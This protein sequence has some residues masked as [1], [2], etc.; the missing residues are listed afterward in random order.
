MNKKEDSQDQECLKDLLSSDPRV[1]KVRIETEKGGLLP[2]ACNWILEDNEFRRWREDGQSTPFWITG[3]PG[4][5]KTMMLC[6]IID[7]LTKDSEANVSFFFCQGTDKRLNSGTAV[8][9]GLLFFLLCKQQH[10]LISHIRHMYDDVGEKL[11]ED[12]NAWFSLSGI[13]KNTLKDPGLRQTY[14]I[15]DALD[16]CLPESRQ[17][18]AKLIVWMSS[19]YP[20]V[21]WVVSSRQLVEFKIHIG[22]AS[23]LS[24]ESR[25]ERVSEAVNAYINSKLTMLREQNL[26]HLKAKK[27]AKEVKERSEGTF[28]WV[29]IVFK[30]LENA[31]DY[32]VMD[33]LKEMPTG[34]NELYG[35]L[36]QDIKSLKWR[37]PEYCQSILRAVTTAF[38]PLTVKEVQEL[39]DLPQD[40]PADTIA[41]M[42]RSLLTLRNDT[43]FLVH[44]SAKDYLT[45]EWNT[46]FR[47]SIRATHES[48]FSKSVEAMA[49]TLEQDIYTLRNTAIH[50]ENIRRPSSDPLA[51]IQYAC[52]YWIS[53][54]IEAQP[55]LAKD[56]VHGFLSVHFLHWF[57]ALSLME[58][59]S[60]CVHALRDLVKLSN[61]VSYV[62]SQ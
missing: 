20:I 19:A 17:L 16:E 44:Q 60:A 6:G 56:Q 11:F 31:Q 40:V 9:R 5:G 13:L 8:L 61:Q 7:E 33:I 4:K 25:E 10:S 50:V 2:S 57:E 34:L 54:L 46:I 42:C 43:I 39:A 58:S 3:A 15:V 24:L 62:A 21:K 48:M 22:Q 1:D 26:T 14:I 49:R 35:K 52:V 53:H 29:S 18:L 12:P 37:N 36:I 28:L 55:C 41:K 27:V 51:S 59:T 32:E 30:E 47:H 23:H 38:R 45:N